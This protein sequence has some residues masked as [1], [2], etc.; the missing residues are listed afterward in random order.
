MAKFSLGIK[1]GV[2]TA[3]TDSV[4][5][6]EGDAQYNDKDRNKAVK[7]STAKEATMV[8]C[9]DG[10]EI[11]G[12]I[13]SVE[14][15]TQDGQTFGT[16]IRKGPL[17]RQYVYAAAALN[18]GDYVVSDAQEAAKTNTGPA[19]HVNNNIGLTKVKKKA[20]GTSG[21]RVVGIKD[22]AAKVYLIEG[23]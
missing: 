1:L 7:Y 9:A 2:N 5:L 12:F 14:G 3:H 11:E 18:L 17:V 15:F 23:V 21:W 10:D 13:A 8:L 22:T 20:S 4:K 16:V 6:G 19:K